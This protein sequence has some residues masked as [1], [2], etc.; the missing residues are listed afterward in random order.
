MQVTISCFSGPLKTLFSVRNTVC[1]LHV[2]MYNVHPC[3]CTYLQQKMQEQETN[4]T[5]GH[6]RW[7]KVLDAY[8]L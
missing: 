4:D 5:V 8:L 6:V 3:T 2:Y 1:I 7:E